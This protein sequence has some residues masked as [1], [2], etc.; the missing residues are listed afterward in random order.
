M[1]AATV[2]VTVIIASATRNSSTNKE[3][4]VVV[5]DA[6]IGMTEIEVAVENL[7][8]RDSSKIEVLKS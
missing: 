6:T 7:E 8:R 2:A 3:E 5:E 1:R 4:M